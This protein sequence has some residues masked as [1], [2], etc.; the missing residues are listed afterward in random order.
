MTPENNGTQAP[1]ISRL[2]HEVCAGSGPGSRP[3]FRQTAGPSRYKTPEEAIVISNDDSIELSTGPAE[4]WP[5]RIAIQDWVEPAVKVT[6]FDDTAR[7]HPGLRAR[8][9]ALETDPVLAKSFSGYVGSAK[10]YH[11]DRWDC[12]EAEIIDRRAREMFKRAL[13]SERATTD[14][15]W[16]NVYRDGDYCLPHSH[17]RATASLVYFLDLGFGGAAA[18]AGGGHGRFCFADPRMKACCQEEPNC[19]TTPVGPAAQEGMLI[20]FPGT[21]VH[22]V[23]V[24]RLPGP[25]I[26]LSWNINADAIAGSPLPA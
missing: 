13:G 11:L 16:A 23:D 10:V 6:V 15:S 1:Q 18:P 2:L 14:L 17:V 25:R 4:V 22:M 12:P 20:M 24:F 8:V 3:S 9:L 21:L 5:D 7:Y 19:M 26:T